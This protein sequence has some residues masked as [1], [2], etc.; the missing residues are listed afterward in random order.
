MGM[1]GQRHVPATLP[2]GKTPYK[3]VY[4]AGWAPGTVWMGVENLTPTGIRSPDLPAHSE[5]L[6]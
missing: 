6:Y 4:E 1:G 3:I 2:P 5:S